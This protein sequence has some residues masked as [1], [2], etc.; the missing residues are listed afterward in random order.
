[1]TIGRWARAATDSCGLRLC[2]K[3]PIRCLLPRR[4]G[5]WLS[6]VIDFRG[7]VICT[8][9]IISKCRGSKRW[10]SILSLVDRVCSE[11]WHEM[12]FRCAISRGGAISRC[13]YHSCAAIEVPV[14]VA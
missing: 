1:M 8:A 13:N 5:H 14:R 12:T 9:T 3:R 11:I 2:V 10:L 6:L 7:S 4:L